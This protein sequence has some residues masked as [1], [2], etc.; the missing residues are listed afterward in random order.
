MFLGIAIGFICGII[1][2]LTAKKI[3]EIII[4]FYWELIK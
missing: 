4:D 1:I 2:T 3:K